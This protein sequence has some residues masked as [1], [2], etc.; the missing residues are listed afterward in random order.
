M[1][2]VLR[3]SLGHPVAVDAG[4]PPSLG[5]LVAVDAGPSS[6]LRAAALSR[7]LINPA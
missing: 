4:P 2:Q 7:R 3:V 5:Q 6:R 1:A